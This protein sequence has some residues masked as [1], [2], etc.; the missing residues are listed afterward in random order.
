MEATK[1]RK[2]KSGEEFEHLFPKP[3]F[4]DPTI[5]K[6]ATVN[7]TV[8]F[9]PQVVQETLFQT[10]KLAPLLKGKG[11]YETCRNI[12]DFVFT[13]IAYKKDADGKEQIRSPARGW[14]DRHHGIDC[15]CYTVFIS[16]ILSNLKIKHKLRITKYK[17]DHFQHIYPIVPTTGENY[18]TVDCVVD[19]FNY[20]EPYTEKKDTNMELEYLNGIPSTNNVDVQDLM[21]WEELDGGDLG[22]LFKRKAASGGGG[23]GAKKGIFKKFT[24][25]PG[26]DG[27]KKGGKLKNFIHKALHVTNRINPA[28]ALIRSGVLISMKLNLFKVAQ[29]LKFA[30]LTDE[31][32]KQKEVDMGKFERLKKVRE[33]LEK[34]FYDAGGKPENLKKAILTGKGNKNHEVSGLGYILDDMSGLDESS[35]LELLLGNEMYHDENFNGLGELGSA[36]ASAASITAATG[37]IGAI[38]G[39]LKGI[40]NIFPKKNKEGKDFENPDSKEGDGTSAEEVS[41]GASNVKITNSDDGGSNTSSSSNDSS[42]SNS[43]NKSSGGD[44]GGGDSGGGDNSKSMAKTSSTNSS[45]GGDSST[46]D[47]SGGDKPQGF[48]DKNKKWLKPTAIGLTGVGLLFLGYKM[49]NKPKPPAQPVSGLKGLKSKKKR[50][51]GHKGKKKQAVAYM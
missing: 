3:L 13:H 41:Q 14:Y 1:K 24:Q 46:T 6:G 20:E 19:R 25:P 23:G 27:G 42:S 32:A 17:E 40:G 47:T 43:E 36:T 50:K 10:E 45:D 39:L 51:G 28:T 49:M 15:D 34:I 35:S 12:W 22:K 48:W 7:D 2:I 9:I 18:I 8:R 31:Q 37:I 26:S 11:V 4:L 29:R 44:G 30:Y 5:K 21:G 33:K 38:A 16:S